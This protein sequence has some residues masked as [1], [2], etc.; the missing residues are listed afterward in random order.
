[1]TGGGDESLSPS[2]VLA[3]SVTAVFAVIFN[4]KAVV[5]PREGLFRAMGVQGSCCRGCLSLLLPVE[6]HQNG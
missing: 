1:M 4:K 5:T 2:F 3:V 6:E